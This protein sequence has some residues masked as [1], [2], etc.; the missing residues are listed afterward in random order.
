MK[1]K[2]DK[3]DNRK[4]RGPQ[5]FSL[6]DNQCIWMKAGII[7]LKL[8]DNAYDCLSCPFDKAMARSL[9]KKGDGASWEKVM[10]AKDQH[11]RECRHMLTGRVQYH[12]CA[13]GYRCN[14]CEFDQYLEESDLTAAFGSV[15][16]N[17]VSG[18]QVADSYYYHRGHSWARVEHGGFVRIGMDDFALK[19]VGRPSEID[20]PKI[21]AQVAQ[22]EVGWQ[23]HK[24][25]KE[26]AVLSPV[27]GIVVATNQKV[28]G[29][30]E[31]ANKDPYGQGWLMV[32]EPTDLRPNLKNLLFEREAAAWVNAEAARLEAKV[33]EAYGMPLAATGG[34]I[35]EDIIGNLPNLNWEDAIHEFLLT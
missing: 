29:Q 25:N 35:V 21:G 10:R 14:V 26:A 24:G 3:A 22:T 8:C 31:L 1:A 19:L 6:T 32:V 5:V 18:F 28:A 33:M 12:Y 34:E 2:A 27:K 15:H 23:I 4:K 11:P 30:P 17:L 20:L 13:N 9:E 7:N 16:T